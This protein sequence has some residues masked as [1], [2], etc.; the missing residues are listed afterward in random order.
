MLFEPGLYIYV[1]A[2]KW[3]LDW[4]SHEL[5]HDTGEWFLTRM[6]LQQ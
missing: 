4:T 2:P 3:R 1:Y 6:T 5:G